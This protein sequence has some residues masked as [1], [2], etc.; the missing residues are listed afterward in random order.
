MEKLENL[1]FTCVSTCYN[2]LLHLLHNNVCGLLGPR[3]LIQLLHRANIPI[4]VPPVVISMVHSNFLV[5]N[6]AVN[7]F[8]YV[9][10]TRKRIISQ[11]FLLRCST[12]FQYQNMVPSLTDLSEYP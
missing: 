8:A 12:E 7:T 9:M 11:C 1:L 10:R 2:K 4:L 3:S 6:V 5:L